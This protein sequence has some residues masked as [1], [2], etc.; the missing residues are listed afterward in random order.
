MDTVG[1]IM[2]VAMRG[3]FALV[4]LVFAG[5]GLYFIGWSVRRLVWTTAISRWH[6]TIGTVTESKVDIDGESDE[7]RYTPAVAYTYQVAGH[8]YTGDHIHYATTGLMTPRQAQQQLNPYPPGARVRV[9]YRPSNPERAI[10][11][12]GFNTAF[13]P[14]LVLGLLFT[15]LGSLGC[16]TALGLIDPSALT[17]WVESPWFARLLPY[18]GLVAGLGVCGLAF[19]MRRR[20]RASR[21]WPRVAGTVVAA[22]I[23]SETSSSNTTAGG[24]LFWPE[25]AF[26]YQVDGRTYTAN[27]VHLVE[28]HSS[29]R[30]PAEEL[31][32]R[33]PV[34]TA[35]EVRYDPDDPSQSLIESTQDGLWLFWLAGL[36]FTAVSSLFIWLGR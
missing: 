36:S 3:F 4:A 15:F 1:T 16:L 7:Y 32:A 22:D 31:V 33:Y 13:A 23:A 6:F 34:G 20:V 35:V 25:I 10:L 30:R 21:S 2:E 19:S 11:E 29:N 14:P 17:G 5:A 27:T 24:R 18:A 28:T 12:P 9:Y 26:E 8:T